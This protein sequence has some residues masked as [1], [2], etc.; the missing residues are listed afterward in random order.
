MAK[1][2]LNEKRIKYKEIDVAKDT[3]AGE[4]LVRESG[5]MGVPVIIIG[6]GD[7]KQVIVGFD[8]GRLEELLR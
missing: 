5:Q 3:K 2:W 4:E 8:Q 7:K 6:E 1:E